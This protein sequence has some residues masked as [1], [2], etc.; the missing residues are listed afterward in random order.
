MMLATN[1]EI[2]D[3]SK[4]QTFTLRACGI[5]FKIAPFFWKVKIKIVRNILGWIWIS[6][7]ILLQIYIMILGLDESY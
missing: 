5:L 3:V 7:Q 1:L 4:V 2:T 6:I